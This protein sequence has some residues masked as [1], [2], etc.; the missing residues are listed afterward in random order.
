[1]LGWLLSGLGIGLFFVASL[2]PPPI[3]GVLLVGALLLLIFGLSAAAGYQVVARRSRLFR[4]PSPIL[5]FVLQVVA[6]N[7]VSIVLQPL[8]FSPAGSTVGFFL[9]TVILLAGYAGVIWL[10]AVRTGAVSWRDMGMPRRLTVGGVL[11]DVGVAVGTMVVVAF[12]AA[13]F[14]GLLA[15]LLGTDAPAV[16]PPAEEGLDLVLVALGAGLLVPIGEELFFRGYSLTA[17]LRERGA[18]SALLRSTIFFAL[19][20]ILSLTS[21]TFE[22]G[23]RQAVLVLAVIGPVGF[24]LGWLFLRRGLI[25]AIAGHAAFNL[26]GVLI[27]FLAENLPPLPPPA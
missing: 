11:G 7:L 17:W 27:T 25:A 20:H 1:L 13:L 23:L 9:T 4:G 12:V 22:E 19:V 26:F 6:V 3:Q 16:V 24:G 10:F 8:G 15:R 2:T 18:R 14:G 5:L 21:T